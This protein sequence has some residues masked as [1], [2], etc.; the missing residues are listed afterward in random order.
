MRK[1]FLV[2]TLVLLALWVARLL[3]CGH[4]SDVTAHGIRLGSLPGGNGQVAPQVTVYGV[5]IVPPRNFPMSDHTGLSLAIVQYLDD[6]RSALGG[7]SP[8]AGGGRLM[9]LTIIFNEP[10]AGA[11]WSSDTRTAWLEWPRI[12]GK[13]RRK[14]FAPLFHYIMVY[15]RRRQNGISFYA[16]FTTEE[17]DAAL[18][19]QR[20]PVA[21]QTHSPKYYGE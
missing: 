13:P 2:L 20:L 11:W 21:I 17:R 18:R 4:G 14:M 12:N 19:G 8:Q 6:A 5:R 7:F 9:P 16:P 15:D 3:G 10:G 1:P